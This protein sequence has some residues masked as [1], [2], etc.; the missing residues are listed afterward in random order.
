MKPIVHILTGKDPR[1][2]LWRRAWFASGLIALVAVIVHTQSGRSLP[3]ST[4][5]VLAQAFEQRVTI[6]RVVK[7]ALQLDAAVIGGDYDAIEPVMAALEENVMLFEQYHDQLTTQSGA[8]IDDPIARLATPFIQI[9]GG[10]EELIIVGKSAERRA[11]YLDNETTGRI[12]RATKGLT[13]HEGQYEAGLAQITALRLQIVDNQREQFLTSSQRGLFVLIALLM[14][15][16]PVVVYP[17]LSAIG[18]FK[19]SDQD[20]AEASDGSG[21]Q[22]FKIE[23][24]PDTKRRAA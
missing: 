11:P 17:V 13:L 22:P 14:C 7:S 1:G 16:T 10:L 3:S 18:S 6:Q 19:P 15:T 21:D 8:G 4:D 9:S 5:D 2:Q 20:G 12:S 23:P 24:Q